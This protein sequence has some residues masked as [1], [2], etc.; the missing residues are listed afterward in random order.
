MKSSCLER[1]CLQKSGRIVIRS[2]FPLPERTRMVPASRSIS[3]T[4]KVA[5]SLTLRPEPYKS[6]AISFGVPDIF[7]NTRRTSWVERTTGS[8]VLRCKRR[9]PS[10]HPGSVSNT[11]RYIKTRALSAWDWVLAETLRWFTKWLRNRSRS[12]FPNVDGWR[13]S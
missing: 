12:A 3:L 11:S 8:R 9:R 5:H 7:S 6:S 2:L 1:L 10:I 13:L 4:R